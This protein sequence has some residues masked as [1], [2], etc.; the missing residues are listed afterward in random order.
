MALR[1]DQGTDLIL[2]MHLQPSG[3]PELVQPSIGLCFTNKPATLHPM[4]LQL[5]N[6][7]A[8]DIP[9]GD[10]NFV[11]TDD[12]TLPDDVDLLAVHPHAH[13]LGKD[14]EATAKLPDGTPTSLIHIRKWGLN[15]QAVY[16]YEQPVFL[17]RGSVVSMRY[18][19]DNSA[20]NVSNPNHP[21]ARVVAGNRSSDE[22]AHLW[23]QVL[24]RGKDSGSDPRRAL[25]EA[26]ARHN[27]DKN[28]AD[29]EAHYNLAAM[30]QARGETADTIQH[31]ERAHELR[32]DNATASN[33]LGTAY[34]TAGN[35]DGAIQCFKDALRIR[36][37]HFD[38]HYNLGTVLASKERFEE[39]AEHFRAAAGLHPDD[40]DAEANLGSALAMTGHVAEAKSHLE[41]ALQIQPDHSLARENLEQLTGA[42]K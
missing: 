32:P 6:D 10:K 23:L 31:Y 4:L 13:Y 36:P 27:V 35:P 9:P 21:P 12:F 2:N 28:P 7:A 1:V 25:Q 29:F 33:S 26:L 17:P 14:L 42:Q 41:R 39:A 8:L 19:Y 15:W 20:G 22:M 16:R 34:V 37:D 11:V 5:E 24:P 3:K 40:A 30:L 38:A 18:M